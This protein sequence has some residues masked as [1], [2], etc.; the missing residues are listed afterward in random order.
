LTGNTELDKK[1]ISK[2]NRDITKKA[3]DI[4]D[5]YQAGKMSAQEAEQELLKLKKLKISKAKP[6]KITVKSVRTAKIRLKKAK[7][8]PAIKLSSPPSVKLTRI[9]RPKNTI[10]FRALPTI[11]APPLTK[12]TGLTV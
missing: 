9:K 4:Y 7:K 11:K 1:A 10:V 5:L 12:I 8:L 6:K 2:F 3:N